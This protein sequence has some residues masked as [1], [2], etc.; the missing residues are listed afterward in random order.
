[1]SF[2]KY[3][4]FYSDENGT[5]MR[6]K[7]K[8]SFSFKAEPKKDTRYRLYTTGETEQFYMWK[9]EPDGPV[10]YRSITDALDSKNALIDRYCLDLSSKRAEEFTKRLYKKIYWVPSVSYLT[11]VELRENWRFGISVK[12]KDISVE[13]G[14]FLRMRVDVR[15]KKEGVSRHAV[16][17]EPDF[18][19]II[20]FPEGSYDWTDF[21]QSIKVPFNTASVGIFIEGKRYSGKCYV[22]RPVFVQ[23]DPEMT[24]MNDKNL[25]P[26]FNESISGKEGFVWL[27]QYLSRKER[28]EFRVKVNGKT[29]YTGEIFERS[30]RH[31][32]WE[33]EIPASLIKEEN[34]VSYE[35]ISDYHDPLPYTIYEAGIIEQP[36]APVSIISV[37]P[38][39]GVD[40]YARILIRTSRPNTKIKLTP[41]SKSLSGGGEYFFEEKGLHGLTLKCISPDVNAS[42][43]IKH[44]KTS[45]TGT[46]ERIVIKKNDDVITGSGDMVYIYQG[47]EEMEEYL[48]WYL[49]NNVGDF[50]TIRPT[51]RWSGTRVLNAPMWKWVTRLFNDLKMK[52][53]V[54]MDGR[55]LPGI[56]AQPGINELAGEGYLGR[57]YHE[58]DGVNFYSTGNQV[59]TAPFAISYSDMGY[60]A[61]EEDPEHTRDRSRIYKGDAVLG[62]C[63]RNRPHDYH[64]CRGL[65]VADLARKAPDITRHTG[66][67]IMF[68]Y[69]VEAGY[70]W[71]GAE[72]MY[73]TMEILV[74]FLRGVAKDEGMTKYGVHHATQWSSSPYDVPEHYR[75]MRLALYVSYMQGATDINTEE[76]YWHMEEYY[77]HHNRFGVACV[78]HTKQQS[79]FFRYISSHSRTGSFH[80][81]FAII[82]GRDDGA[83]FFIKNTVWGVLARQTPADDSWDLFTT[84]YPQSKPAECIYIHCCP[85]DRPVGYHTSTPYGNPDMIPMEAKPETLNGY[86]TIFFLGYN[87]MEKQDAEK[88]LDKVKAGA[89]LLMTRAHNTLTSDMEAI[90]RGE[91]IFEDNAL[92]FTDGEPVFEDSTFN[93]KSVSVCVNATPADE[94]ILYTDDGKPLLCR[95]AIGDGEVILFNTKDYPISPAIRGAY[96]KQIVRLVKKA[97]DQEKVWAST[98]DDVQFAVYDQNDGSKHIYFLAVDWYRPEEDLRHATLRI[99]T[100]SY[101]VA[102]PFGVMLKAVTDKEN[103]VAVWANSENAEVLSVSDGEVTVQG[104][105]IIEF[106]VAK[107]GVLRN[108]T[109]DFSENPVQTLSI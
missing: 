55:E 17:G 51:Y 85:N 92:S 37:S 64:L 20:N 56:S 99:G 27:G 48:S 23:N 49:S 12:G 32:E 7:G 22:E 21:S 60:F 35:L 58:V 50:I 33:L 81:P 25:L 68:K 43:V 44:G 71:L 63:D 10:L 29:I 80:T 14:G 88:L 84:V 40:G 65:A 47:D 26:T 75:R 11:Y 38:F 9:D 98:G 106:T 86:K 109:V 8:A 5:T 53:V 96:E 89:S 72:T 107:G 34:T 74:G 67:S 42:F 61:Y 24:F 102:L 57:Q 104:G 78:N 59:T 83:D 76:G 2:E 4:P 45:L 46:V 52:Y 93:G 101:D 6:P 18:R 19:Y 87:R 69:F 62:I 103:T 82:H 79:D 30:H 91:L 39:A 13:D 54:M 41:K 1:M 3:C 77:E 31:S 28:P 16:E 108:L 95:Y 70:E 105:G 73:S 15:L 94:V 100:D 90:K 36:G 97:N 66:P